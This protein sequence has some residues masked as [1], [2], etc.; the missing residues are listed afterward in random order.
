[1]FEYGSR[2]KYQG[3]LASLLRER[4]AVGLAGKVSSQSLAAIVED[5]MCSSISDSESMT[6]P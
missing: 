3:D 1:M 2:V 6:R 5:E 4:I